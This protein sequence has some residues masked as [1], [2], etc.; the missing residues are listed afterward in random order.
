MSMLQRQTPEGIGHGLI[1]S[2]N[3]LAIFMLL[4]PCIGAA[5]MPQRFDV[6]AFGAVGD[7]VAD[8]Q[9]AIVKAAQAVTQN[10]GGVLYFP[11][12][13][14]RCAR[15]AGM[16]NG[17][18]FI[19]IS[20][21]TILFDPGAVLLM[22]NLNPDN[23]N[24]D[25]GHGILIRG[26]CHDI[27]IMNAA[28]KWA[29]KPGARSHGDAF[30][31]EGFPDD[32]KCISN[33]R[34]LQCSAELSPQTGAVLMGCSDVYVENF[35]VTRTYADGL[36]FN[37][38]RRIQVNGVTGIETG[39]DTLSFMTYEDDKAVD[40][41]SGGPGS[42]AYAS[43]GE[44]NSNGSTAT[45]IYAKGGTAN[46]VRFGGAINV[47]LSNVI[48]EGKLRA[49]I[50]DCGKKDP[51]RASWSW[52]ANRG[53]V[54]SNVV[55]INCTTAFYVWNYNNAPLSGDDKWWRHDIQ[56]SNLSARD[57]KDDSIFIADAAGVAVRGVKA[58]GRRIRV[59]HARDCTLSDIDLKNGELVVEGSADASAMGKEPSLDLKLRHLD[60]D[61]GYLDLH[62]CK[63]LTCTDGR[64]TRPVG[65]GLRTGNLVDSR[66]DGISVDRSKGTSTGP[67]SAAP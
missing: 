15:Q 13:V 60:I 40:A 65:E 48:V 49:I 5:K 51:P 26:P 55:A 21:V 36:H 1:M 54:I 18:E 45:N 2:R 62:N 37:A 59:L 23:G 3:A 53:I 46:G 29:K 6:R 11:R 19:G 61:N 52:L 10:K 22:D 30:R 47:A 4:L 43:W 38:C 50:S 9:P 17:I 8:D 41:Y 33:I 42:F 56:L 31:F 34:L 44:W 66:V 58:R 14:Y 16:Q 24:G 39:D 12:G 35:R 7:G 28:V 64:I 27:T 25:R 57:C 20:N 63:G 32:D 67:G